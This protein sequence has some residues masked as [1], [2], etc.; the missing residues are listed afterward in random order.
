MSRRRRLRV[1]AFSSVRARCAGASSGANTARK[2]SSASAL[3]AATRTTAVGSDESHSSWAYASAS[4][5]LPRNSLRQ[6]RGERTCTVACGSPLPNVTWARPSSSTV[7]LPEWIRLNSAYAIARAIRVVT[8]SPRRSVMRST[9]SCHDL[10]GMRVHRHALQLQT[11]S[12]G[13]DQREHPQRT[14]R[15]ARAHAR[16]RRV[17]ELAP[18]QRERG[19]ER[20][21]SIARARDVHRQ[22]L[23]RRAHA[24]L[25]AL[26]HAHERRDV[27]SLG[28]IAGEHRAGGLDG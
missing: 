12:L 19:V 6:A 27:Q 18:M 10:L 20:Y 8:P 17:G 22:R 9:Y 16:K 24:P 23:A 25:V 1:L 13:V 14:R 5:L 3:R 4:P 26:V 28:R 21:V 7:R 2:R 11:Q 15:I